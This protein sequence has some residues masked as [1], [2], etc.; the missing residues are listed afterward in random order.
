MTAAA[1]TQLVFKWTRMLLLTMSIA[2]PTFKMSDNITVMLSTPKRK[3]RMKLSLPPKLVE[4]TLMKPLGKKKLLIKPERALK[5]IDYAMMFVP[6]LGG[7]L[8]R[9]LYIRSYWCLD[10]LKNF[11]PA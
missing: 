9:M 6:V 8:V 5:N 1:T 7:Y 3:D 10:H 4:K 2:A 11:K